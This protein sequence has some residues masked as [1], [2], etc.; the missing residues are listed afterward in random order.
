MKPNGSNDKTADTDLTLRNRRLVKNL[1][2]G[3]LKRF[4]N[5]ERAARNNVKAQ[6]DKHQ[7]IEKKLEI[8]KRKYR[9]ENQEKLRATTVHE[10]R[11]RFEDVESTRKRAINKV[12]ENE[13]H[14]RLLKKFI[15]TDTKPTIF[16]LPA[17]HSDKTKELLKQCANKIDR[18]IVRRREELRSDSDSD[19]FSEKK[20]LK[21]EYTVVENRKSG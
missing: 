13:R 20:R 5:E 21:S 10:N 15:Q 4:E 12:E 9:M 18:L 14:M 1:V 19:G 3:T 6:M 7:E 11:L 8:E 17:Q 16:Y 2:I